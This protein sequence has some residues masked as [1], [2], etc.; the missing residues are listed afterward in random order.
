MAA[1]VA[2][3]FVVSIIHNNKPIRELSEEGKRITRI[4]FGSEY[5]IRLK[6]K[7]H[8]RAYT[9][10]YIDGTDVT[11]AGKI[12][13]NAGQTLDL[14]RFLEDAHSG[15]KFKFVEAS[16]GAVQDPT[17]G[18]NGHVQVVFEPEDTVAELKKTLSNVCKRAPGGIAGV[19]DMSGILR[20]AGF[21]GH[22]HQ[23]AQAADHVN[24]NTG[25]ASG[26]V[27]YGAGVAP[28]STLIT[29]AVG[30][31]GMGHTY[32]DYPMP[33]EVSLSDAGATV[34]GS[35]SSQGFSI[36][37]ENFA[38]LPS[39]TIDL[40][41]KGPKVELPQAPL[42]KLDVSWVFRVGAKG[43]QEVVCGGVSL[44]MSQVDYTSWDG[45]VAHTTVSGVQYMLT[46]GTW[47]IEIV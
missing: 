14:E 24:V 26:Y 9:K 30:G 18:A 31:I 15:K 8:A 44:P 5:A 38:T 33:Q 42:L 4:P 46:S 6:N 45:E 36:S 3:G 25:G 32:V 7:S 12:I 21:L 27:G 16:N 13:L 28:T 11:G 34:E 1:Y 35:H 47:R 39:V 40:W 23:P 10:V 41:I 2:P 22:H 43:L 19:Q 37:H 20:G 17:S 29:N